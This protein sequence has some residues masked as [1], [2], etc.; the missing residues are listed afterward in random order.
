M[1]VVVILGN[2]WLIVSCHS[3]MFVVVILGNV[4]LIVSCHSLMF[5]VVILYMYLFP[6]TLIFC[7]FLYF[8]NL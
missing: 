4:W 6:E 7:L 2:V 8:K 1:F 3:W 5:V